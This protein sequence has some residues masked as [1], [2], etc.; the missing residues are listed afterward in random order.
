VDRLIDPGQVTDWIPARVSWQAGEPLVD[1][2]YQG[3]QRIPVVNFDQI[4][5]KCF[6]LPFNLLF[7]HQTSMEV[8]SRVDQ[9]RPGMKPTGL[10]F[11]SSRPGSRLLLRM[12]AAVPANACLSEAQ[13]LDSLLRAKRFNP[14]VTEAQRVEWVRLIVSCLAGP[15]REGERHLFIKFHAWNI[16]DL[17][18]IRLAFPD[19]PWIFVYRDPDEELISQM[20][21][22]D[23]HMIPGVI[24]PQLFEMDHVTISHL[25]PE[26]YC[27]KVLRAIYEAALQSLPDGG[28]LINSAELPQAL[29]P[30][31]GF[32]GQPWTDLEK[33][34]MASVTTGSPTLQRGS[35]LKRKRP[36]ERLS[37]A[38][39][40]W[41]YPVYAALEQ[42]RLAQPQL[43]ACDRL[44]AVRS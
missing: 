36:S 13:P 35:G 30:I 39:Q 7:R 14:A 44:A 22:R 4:L 41:V 21:Q 19:V 33:D 1:W 43:A 17:R 23:A 3:R 6:E 31:S 34:V 37:K 40:T 8:L 12:L 15:G 20:N 29:S 28:L 18:I 9:T 16:F 42:A 25:A 2:C 11:H 27:A 24:D 5:N 38:A 32:F 26:D 10:I